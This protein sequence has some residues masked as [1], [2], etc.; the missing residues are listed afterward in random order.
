MTF[1][2]HHGFHQT[3]GDTIPD[4]KRV[5]Y[6]DLINYSLS[7]QVNPVTHVQGRALVNEGYGSIVDAINLFNTRNDVKKLSTPDR[8]NKFYELYKNDKNLGGVLN[9]LNNLN[10]GP[11]TM[12]DTSN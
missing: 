11:T 5:Y 6:S 3:G 9:Q 12:Y 4:K 1:K 8:I 10:Y 2:K 7:Q